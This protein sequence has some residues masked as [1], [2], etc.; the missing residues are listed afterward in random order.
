MRVSV[1]PRIFLIDMVLFDALYVDFAEDFELKRYS[2]TDSAG[3]VFA[4]KFTLISLLRRIFI[5][6]LYVYIFHYLVFSTLDKIL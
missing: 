2:S 1:D 5:S 4:I 3:P 6:F